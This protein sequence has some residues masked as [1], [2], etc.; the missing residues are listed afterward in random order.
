MSDTVQSV[1]DRFVA[2]LRSAMVAD[3]A[4]ALGGVKREEPVKAPVK[5]VGPAA[6]KAAAM[7]MRQ[8]KAYEAILLSINAGKS[9]RAA[10]MDHTGVSE[11][12][13][14][15]AIRQM[16]ANNDVRRTGDKRAARYEV[17]R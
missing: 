15:T 11:Y 12:Q 8:F 1:I 17:V 2:D 16:I 4:A 3:V 7:S 13:W 6:K 10:I 9:T 5:K 14:E